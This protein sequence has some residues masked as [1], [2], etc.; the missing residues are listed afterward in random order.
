MLHNKD[1]IDSFYN[2]GLESD[3]FSDENKPVVSSL[4]EIY[5]KHDVLLTRKSFRE[6]IKDNPVPKERISHELAFNSCY[7]ATS[8]MADLPMLLQKVIDSNVKNSTIKAL[9]KYSKDN[10]KLGNIPAIKNLIND[11]EDILKGARVSKDKSYYDDIRSLS[12]T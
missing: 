7:S 6:K 12:D 11:C 9:E 5:D 10:K 2:T 4:L 1:A 3:L 8:N